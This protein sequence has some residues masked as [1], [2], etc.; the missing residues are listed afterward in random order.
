MKHTISGNNFHG[1][2]SINFYGEKEGFILSKSQERKLNNALCG[3]ETCKCGGG[4]GDGIDDDSASW[5]YVGHGETRLIPLSE[6]EEDLRR[7][8]EREKESSRREEEE[9]KNARLA[10]EADYN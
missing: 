5:E 6:R 3:I 8:M 7:E 4:Y 1:N 9:Y 10:L 2:Y